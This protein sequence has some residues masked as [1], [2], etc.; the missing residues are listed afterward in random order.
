MGG[1]LIRG[2]AKTI[3][4]GTRLLVWDKIPAALAGVAGHQGV[5]VAESLDS[6]VEQA[7]VIVVVVKPKD[8]D[9]LLRSLA[10]ALRP[11]HTVVSAMAG[12][13]LAQIRQA[14]GPVPAVFRV[15]P[16]LGVEVGAGMAGVC[17]EPDAPAAAQARVAGLFDALGVA[18]VVP[19][20]MMDIVTALSGS[21]PALFALALEGLEDGGV[22]SGLPRALSRRFARAAMLGA[23]RTMVAGEHP[24]TSTGA[25]ALAG[26]DLPD[27]LSLLD[28]LG[29]RSAFEEAVLAAARRSREMRAPAK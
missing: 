8:G 13:E 14:A 6:L 20:D 15:M 1:A 4:A 22:L 18:V 26:A 7:A 29:V 9:A 16:N 19:E 5:A 25:T 21:G 12:V 10:P 2:W 27:G 3:G 28:E 24:G 17:A 23:A 11:D